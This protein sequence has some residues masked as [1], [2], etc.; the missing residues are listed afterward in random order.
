MRRRLVAYS[1]E[2]IGMGIG[3]RLR[4]GTVG[5]PGFVLF[6]LAPMVGEL[7]SGSS[8]PVEFFNPFGLALLS[9]LYGGGAI[10]ARELMRRW[11]KGWGALLLLG[12]AYGIVE[13][14]LMVKSFFD[15]NWVDLGALGHYGGGAAST[16]SGRSSSPSI[17]PCSASLYPSY[18]SS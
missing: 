12:A 4:R 5:S 7:L 13:E 2:V 8:P 6:F 17:T 14:G 9:L 1:S 15:P 11:G 18:S 16:G 3:A 10:I